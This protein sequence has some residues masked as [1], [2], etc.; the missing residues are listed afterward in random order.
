MSNKANKRTFEYDLAD[1]PMIAHAFAI[2]A[3]TAMLCGHQNA[4]EKFKA[5]RA[6]IRQFVPPEAD[7]FDEEVIGEIG[8]ALVKAET[9][10]VTVINPSWRKDERL[11]DCVIAVYVGK[12]CWTSNSLSTKKKINPGSPLI[13]KVFDYIQ[14]LAPMDCKGTIDLRLGEIYVWRD[15][16]ACDEPKVTW[17]EKDQTFPYGVAPDQVEL[18]VRVPFGNCAACGFEFTDSKAEAI[19]AAAVKKHLER[20]VA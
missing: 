20:R 1:A 9:F 17:S 19:H 10:H 18:A 6:I 7:I 3:S 5:Y 2:A 4:K 16:P 13:K 8:I 15:C 14:E 11:Y 12:R